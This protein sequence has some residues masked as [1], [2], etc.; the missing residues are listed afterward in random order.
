L[1]IADSH[2]NVIRKVDTFGI[3]T[4]IAGNGTGGYSGDGGSATAAKLNSPVSISINNQ[5]IYVADIN[6]NV[7]RKID[8]FGIIST[9]AGNGTRGYTG[10]GLLA[11]YASIN[12]PLGLVVDQYGNFYFGDVFDFVV[13]KVDTVHALA[14]ITP[15]IKSNSLRVFPDP[16]TTELT[17]ASLDPIFELEIIDDIGQMIYN[18][19]TRG[20]LQ[21]HI[22]VVNFPVGIYFIKINGMELTEFL[23]Q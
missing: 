9:V 1:F 18:V 13:R 10:D 7:I 6:N 3:I 17:I 22:N 16:A 21:M 20:V 19:T 4:T 11:V 5:G 14:G 12:Q 2:N 23:K 8:V 15:V